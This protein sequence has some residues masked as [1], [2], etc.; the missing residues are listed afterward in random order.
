MTTHTSSKPA[1]HLRELA[2]RTADRITVALL[3]RPGDPDVLLR[4]D[5]ARTGV[6][7][8]VDVPGRDALAAYEHPFAYAG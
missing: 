1:A 5:D 7:F 2:V 3:W 6:H 4:V 8:E